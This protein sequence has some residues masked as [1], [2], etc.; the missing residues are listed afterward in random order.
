MQNET[1][2]E[3]VIRQMVIHGIKDSVNDLILSQ[4]GIGSIPA[5]TSA[6]SSPRVKSPSNHAWMAFVAGKI[7]KRLYTHGHK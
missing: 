2:R 4:L 1:V 3:D 5:L 7:F 6:D